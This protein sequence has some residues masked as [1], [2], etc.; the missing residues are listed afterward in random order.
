MC[1]LVGSD[2]WGVLSLELHDRIYQQMTQ[3]KDAVQMMKKAFIMPE[4]FYKLN[5]LVFS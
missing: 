5:A 2:F 1:L 4:D 3:Q